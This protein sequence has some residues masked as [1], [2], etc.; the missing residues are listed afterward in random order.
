MIGAALARA[1]RRLVLGALLMLAPTALAAQSP[2][3]NDARATML[4]AAAKEAMR[5]DPA[6]ALSLALRAEAQLK[7]GARRYP[8]RVAEALWLA[9]EASLR[10]N[11][12]E[13]AAPWINRALELIAAMPTSKLRGDL[14]LSRGGIATIRADAAQ[15]LADYQQA[16]NIFRNIGETRSQ[17]IALQQIASLYRDGGDYEMAIRYDREA[18]EIYK[19][20]PNMTVTTYNNQGN[21][22][23][24]LGRY[25]KA[26]KFYDIALASANHMDSD[27]SA[28]KIL[29]NKA[30]AYLLNNRIRQAKEA[31]QEGLFRASRPESINARPKL[32]AV[33]AQAELQAGNFKKAAALIGEVFE[34]EDLSATSLKFAESHETAYRIFRALGDDKM[35]LAHLEALK[36]LDDKA[37]KLAASTNTALMAARFDYANQNLKIANLKAEEARR[38]LAFEHARA[39]TQQFIFLGLGLVALI[40]GALLTFSLL[41]IR[42]SRNEVRAANVDLEATNSKLHR[43]LAAKTEFLATTSH[44]IRTP[45]NGILGM[46]QVMLAD[47]ALAGDVRDRLEVV[48]SAGV[49]M[50]A[51]VDDI[52]DVAKMESGNLTIE[53]VPVALPALL[54]DVARLWEAPA[55][56]RG[57]RFTTAIEGL[58]EWVSADPARV[59]QI[60]FNLLSNAMKF[61]R[62]GEVALRTRVAGGMI[63]ILVSDSGI[64]IPAHK[65]DEIFEAFRQVD[66]STTRRFG[67]T[68]LGLAICRKLARAMGGDVTV[69]STPGSGSCFRLLMPHR[70]AAAPVTAEAPAPALLIVDPNPIARAMWNAALAPAAGVVALAA[71]LAEAQTLLARGAPPKLLIDAAALPAAMPDSTLASL[72]AQLGPAG[73][74]YLMQR[75]GDVEVAGVTPVPKPIAA[76]PLREILYPAP[77]AATAADESL[78]SHAA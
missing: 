46:T 13:R 52:L 61:T 59:R 55:R 1:V 10:L 25:K 33:E 28:A 58:P 54:R 20:D 32:I 70:A 48:Q 50:K 74:V 29:G 38:Q 11:D 22:L 51:L 3:A 62:H 49:T 64:G 77:K 72:V 66:A 36:R 42:R 78:V 63:E 5:A 57:L 16:H 35:A 18:A 26:I 65:L 69:E 75:G 43:A 37:T 7:A 39:R 45:L 76:G 41:V 21:S 23:A 31:I 4:I 27:I 19:S 30:R 9:G 67:G 24:A 60:V 53:A 34:K 17:S 40:I 68:G 71:D 8:V 15:A 47:S 56:E 2:V 6:R 44:E 12:A 14:L 73:R